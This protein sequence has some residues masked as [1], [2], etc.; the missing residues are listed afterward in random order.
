[1]TWRI[2]AKALMAAKNI[3]QKDLLDVFNVS[4]R[5]AIGHYLKGRRQPCIEQ[6]NALATKLGCTINELLE[7]TTSE[8]INL[9][10][11]DQITEDLSHYTS[12]I[13]LQTQVID[14]KYWQS[15]TP[16]VRALVEDIII[17]SETGLLNSENILILQSMVNALSSQ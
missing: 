5:G 2:K 15:L 11:N 10:N 17:K 1:M 14:S 16:Q 12:K 13:I 9:N 6:L 3:R 4:T 8:D 7:D